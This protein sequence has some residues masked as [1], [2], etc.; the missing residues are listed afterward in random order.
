MDKQY[1]QLRNHHTKPPRSAAVENFF[2]HFTFLEGQKCVV[3]IPSFIHCL[4]TLFPILFLPR[5]KDTQI[6][7]QRYKLWQRI[8][9]EIW[10]R[11]P[12]TIEI[13]ILHLTTWKT[14]SNPSSTETNFFSAILGCCSPNPVPKTL[15]PVRVMQLPQA[16]RW[17]LGKHQ[18]IGRSLILQAPQEPFWNLGNLECPKKGRCQSCKT[19]SYSL[20]NKERKDYIM[21][22]LFQR[23]KKEE[24]RASESLSTMIEFSKKEVWITCIFLICL[25]KP[26]WTCGWNSWEGQQHNAKQLS[27]GGQKR[28]ETV[29]VASLF[30]HVL[31][32]KK[33]L[34]E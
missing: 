15:R 6:F 28:S 12:N 25:M 22:T 18:T 31:L 33:C 32:Y 27:A 9:N 13:F 34:G 3:P 26:H 4:Q 19:K 8:I 1:F 23:S 10:N 5:K 7:S 24:G 21:Y 29:A 2:D 17:S 11:A 14:V 20:P 30:T 16:W